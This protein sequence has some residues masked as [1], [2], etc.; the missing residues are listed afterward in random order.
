MLLGEPERKVGDQEQRRRTKEKPFFV[1]LAGFLPASILLSLL[2][3]LDT[4]LRR[5]DECTVMAIATSY[6]ITSTGF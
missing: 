3:I 4:G 1:I 2:I 6:Q 5:Y